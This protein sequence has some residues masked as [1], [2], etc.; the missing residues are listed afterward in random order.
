MDIND[1][2]GLSLRI[3]VIVS[4]ILIATGSLLTFVEHGSNGYS[5][6]ELLSRTSVVNSSTASFNFIVN[7]VSQFTGL[8]L[9]YL[10]LVVLIA[11]PVIR[12]MLSVLYFA[13]DKNL[14]Y[15]IVTAIVLFNLL[16]AIFV[17]PIFVVHN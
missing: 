2:I 4:V 15:T 5:V 6:S 17:I 1:V 9:I 8:G 13:L 10:G 11:T 16:I 7:S 12:V 14:L 3:G